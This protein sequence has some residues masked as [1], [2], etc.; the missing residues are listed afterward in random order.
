[1][2]GRPRPSTICPLL[3]FTSFLFLLSVWRR[4]LSSSGAVLSG[5]IGFYLIFFSHHYAVLSSSRITLGFPDWLP[6]LFPLRT[7][8]SCKPFFFS[9]LTTR[10]VRPHRFDCW[11]ARNLRPACRPPLVSLFTFFRSLGEVVS[12]ALTVPIRQFKRPFP[13]EAFTP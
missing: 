5:V 10:T 12:F 8:R 9:L 4:H 6:L 3:S 2:V 1:M 13:V 7:L 11:R